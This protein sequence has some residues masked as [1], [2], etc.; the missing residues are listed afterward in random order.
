[1]ADNSEINISQSLMKELN[2]YRLGKSCGRVFVEKYI[3]KRFDIF[4]PTKVMQLGNFFEYKCIGATTKTNNIPQPDYLKDGKTLTEPYKKAM[5]QV[6]NFK[7]FIAYYGIE[8]TSVQEKWVIDGLEGTLDFIG[9]ATRDIKDKDGNV[10]ISKGEKFICDIKFSGMINDAYSEFGWNTS[11]LSEKER[12]ILQPIHYKFLSKLKYGI[13]YKFLFL[14][15]SSTNEYEYKSILFNTTEED[16]ELHKT[17][18]ATTAAWMKHYLK[19]GFKEVP[20]YMRCKDC[21]LKVNCK[22]YMAI[23]EIT[24]FELNTNAIE[25]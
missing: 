9:L 19:K 4:L 7:N 3:N 25:K 14:I 5:S 23:P 20:E 17:F 13:E 11:R 8:I 2:D 6:D 24:V 12:L 22:S 18:I 1:M 16:M 10:V 21:P 15:F